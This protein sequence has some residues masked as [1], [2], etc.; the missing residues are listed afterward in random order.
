MTISLPIFQTALPGKVDQ[1]KSQLSYP[2]IQNIPVLLDSGCP[3]YDCISQEV[4]NK[5]MLDILLYILTLLYV[6]GFNNECND[7]F[8]S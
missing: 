5:L 2:E 1:R 7:N 6:V 3:L 8:P 4:V